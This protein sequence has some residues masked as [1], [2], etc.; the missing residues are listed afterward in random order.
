MR[1]SGS[2]DVPLLLAQAREGSECAWG[3][4][5]ENYRSYLALLARL[6]VGKRLAGRVDPEDLVQETFLQAHRYREQFRGTTEEALVAWLRRILASRLAHT[7]R[8][9][10]G[11][12][13]RDPRLEQQ[14]ASDLDQSS[15]VLD[16]GLVAGE[17]SPSSQAAR[18]EQT[19]RLAQALEQLPRDYRE[20][21]VLRHL[22]GL[23]FPAVAR[24]M[25]RTE[26]SVVALWARALVQL[27]SRLGPAP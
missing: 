21:L 2:T 5:L 22:E 24:R 6:Q 4:L 8:H 27:R 25:G 14:L 20:V 26:K 11:T 19:V 18:R 13:A 23:A 17:S 12:A 15:R 16:Q 10:F 7:I 1:M 3:D 9:W